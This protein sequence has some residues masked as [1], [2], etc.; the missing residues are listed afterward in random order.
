MIASAKARTRHEARGLTEVPGQGEDWH[1]CHSE[2]EDVDRI[3]TIA[4]TRGLI[5]ILNEE[6]ESLSELRRGLR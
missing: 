3:G 6:I 2:D 1:D 4:R 5:E